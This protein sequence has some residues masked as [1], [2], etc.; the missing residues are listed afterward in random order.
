MT[1]EER[2]MLRESI[3]E[4]A[5]LLHARLEKVF[6]ETPQMTLGQMSEVSDI[7]KDLSETEKNLAKARRCDMEHPHYEE[8][9]Y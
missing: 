1:H 3:D 7:I 9:K 6:A 2:I 4:K 5:H 8:K